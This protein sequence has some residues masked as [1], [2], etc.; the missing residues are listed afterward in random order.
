MF[1]A[2]VHP[3]C[4]AQSGNPSDPA[5]RPRDHA[6]PS[7]NTPSLLVLLGS[8]CSAPSAWAALLVLPHTRLS[9]FSVHTPDSSEPPLL[10]KQDDRG[11]RCSEGAPRIP[12]RCALGS[13]A[14]ACL[15]CVSTS[16]AKRTATTPGCCDP[17]FCNSSCQVVSVHPVECWQM[18]RCVLWKQSSFFSRLTVSSM[19]LLRAPY[20]TTAI[21]L[22]YPFAQ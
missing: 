17:N 10:L 3:E 15:T 19:I 2:Y 5:V 11:L 12:C 9:C 8:Q 16:L 1:H 14:P 20:L 18:L 6:P 4:T 7:T 21:F 22:G 13:C